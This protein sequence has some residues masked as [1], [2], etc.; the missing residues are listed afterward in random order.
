MPSEALGRL[1]DVG[2][3]WA[4][5]DLDTADGAT[6]LRVNMTMHQAVTF[7]VVAA[8]GATTA[9]T[10][11]LKQ[12][13]AYT[14]GTS[15]NLASATVTGSYGITRFHIKSEAVLDNDEAWTT[16]TQA[17]AATIALAGATYGDKQYILALEV[18]A[19]QLAP[20]YTHCSLDFAATLGA[21]KLATCLVLPH[22]LRFQ[23]KPSSL[24]NILR[25]GVANV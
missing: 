9:A 22:D 23:R 15:N 20:T 21:A 7:L 14:S 13:T 6:G 18:R 4:P 1:F 2:T 24:G 12:H 25:P 11:T 10:L 8:A 5:V 17:E 3:G 19:D 16:V